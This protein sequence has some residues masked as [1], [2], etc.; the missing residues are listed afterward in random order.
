MINL[1]DK[2]FIG[3]G[4]PRDEIKSIRTRG[5]WYAGM[6]VMLGVTFAVPA[7]ALVG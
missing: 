6:L 5:R 7:S 1:M 4:L 2:I 3:I